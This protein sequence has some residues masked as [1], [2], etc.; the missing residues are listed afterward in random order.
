[1]AEQPKASGT[2]SLSDILSAI[3]NIVQGVNALAQTYLQVEGLTLTAAISVPTVIKAAPGRIARIDVTTAGSA[4]GTIYDGASLAAT[5][6][7]FHVIP[8]TLGIQVIMLP[9]AYGL[10]VS[11]GTGQV[12]SVSWS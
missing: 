11:P 9:T 3:K 8:M 5:T 2:T 6:K 1:M 12:L 7:P 4:T 10:L